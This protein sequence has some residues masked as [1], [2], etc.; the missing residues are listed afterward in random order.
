MQ[1]GAKGANWGNIAASLAQH[2]GIKPRESTALTKDE[3]LQIL[4]QGIMQ[5]GLYALQEHK[6]S[7]MQ[8]HAKLTQELFAI[9]VQV[10]PAE[11]FFESFLKTQQIAQEEATEIQ[12]KL[13][14]YK[15]IMGQAVQLTEAMKRHNQQLVQSMD[16]PKEIKACA[17][18]EN[19]AVLKKF[20]ED[21][22]DHLSKAH[23]NLALR[24]AAAN[25]RSANL[26]L[27]LERYADPLSKGTESGQNALQVAIIKGHPAA[28]KLL[29]RASDA[30]GLTNPLGQL[31]AVDGRGMTALAHLEAL[32]D[33]GIKNQIREEILAA[34]QELFDPDKDERQKWDQVSTRLATPFT[35]AAAPKAEGKS[36]AKLTPP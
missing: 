31:E 22:K 26:T 2:L 13:L 21:F 25:N 29:L 33:L 4:E 11:T 36:E 1:R 17:S 34:L 15:A 9:A 32:G 8:N 23:L 16:F 18:Q 27:L 28:V 14:A 3:A 20:L 12:E 30:M 35:A 10:I 19:A 6:F 5:G 24:N 7:G